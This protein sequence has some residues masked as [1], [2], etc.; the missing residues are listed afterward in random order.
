MK[1][2]WRI[3]ILI[4]ALL[5]SVIAIA[6]NPFHSGVLITEVFPNSSAFFEGLRE[7]QTITHVDQTTVKDLADYSEILNEKF[8]SQEQVK[9]TFTL[10]SGESIILFTNTTPDIVVA[11]IPSTK[12]KVGLDLQ[13]GARAIVKAKNHTL[14]SIE[15]GDLVEVMGNRLNVYGISDV[16]V[17]PVSD[18]EGNNFML[19]EI[20]GATT[21]DIQSLISQQGKFE[22]KIGNS[23]IFRGGNEDI[24][25]VCKNDATCAGIDRCDPSA[26]GETCSFR[27]VIYLS[28]DAAQRQAD[29]T[30]NLSINITSSGSYLSQSLDLYLDDQ[31][32][33]SLLISEGLRG[34][35]TTQI[36]IQGSESGATRD[37]AIKNTEEAMKKLQTILITGSLPYQLEIVKL[38]TISPR[39]G[40]SFIRTILL[41]GALAIILVSLF[42]FIRYRNIKQSLAVLLT[43]LS[44]VVIILGIA[45]FIK[46][47]L[48]LPSIAGILAT[49][50]TGVDQQIVIL[51][52]SIQKN[53]LS[54]KEKMKR[55]L[56]ILMATYFTAVVSLLPLMVAGAGLLRGF[57]VTTIIGVTAG[58]LISRPAFADM[59]KNIEE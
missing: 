41:A 14:N 29:M 46:W 59:I 32:V 57:A 27:F 34:Q 53:A 30:N 55:A 7:G 47:N 8:P 15:V 20:A 21:A 56:L 1:L 16:Q 26:E 58:I 23:T 44:E 12:I 18:L 4:L 17:R 19:V 11:S 10:K 51:D 35:A 6:P 25:S 31:L 13:G 45:S 49:I 3:W 52:E 36:Q 48:D 37:E 33:D 5:F 39:L 28:E 40:Q 2:T 50:G 9:T 54:L 38:D 24:I 22:A 43:S 42:V